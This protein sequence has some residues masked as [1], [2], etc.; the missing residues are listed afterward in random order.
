MRCKLNL[1]CRKIQQNNQL[2]FWL[3]LFPWR[4]YAH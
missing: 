2:E 3:H 4:S 1:F